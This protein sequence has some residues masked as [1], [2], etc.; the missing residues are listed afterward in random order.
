MHGQRPQM[1]PLQPPRVLHRAPVIKVA[2][3]QVGLQLRDEQ[4]IERRPVLHRQ[5]RPE[6]QV[7]DILDARLDRALLQPFAGAQNSARNG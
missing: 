2:R 4:R 6:H 1:L 5:L 3:R 7:A